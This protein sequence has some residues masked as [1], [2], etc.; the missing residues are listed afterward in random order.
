VS[1]AR[2][3]S[4]ARSPRARVRG[5]ARVPRILRARLALRA[6]Q[7]QRSARVS[8][9]EARRDLW[10][11]SGAYSGDLWTRVASQ[12]DPTGKE[13]VVTLSVTHDI[14]ADVDHFIANS[15]LQV[16]RRVESRPFA[17]SGPEVD[18][19]CRSRCCARSR[20]RRGVTSSS[21]RTDLER[22]PLRCGAERVDVL[23]RT[24]AGGV[25]AAA[26]LPVRFSFERDS[27]YAASIATPHKATTEE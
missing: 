16:G 9:A 5:H 17:G 6:E 2:T 4:S 20:V 1:C 8:G 7:H 22:P 18:C 10:K 14:C 26:D 19:E 25:G 11:P 24:A 23:H 21:D 13:A 12:P 27:S 15:K 3:R